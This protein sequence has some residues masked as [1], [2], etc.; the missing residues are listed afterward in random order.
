MTSNI[1]LLI[2]F[3]LRIRSNDGIIYMQIITVLHIYLSEYG[4]RLRVMNDADISEFKQ[5]IYL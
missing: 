4:K 3:R 1:L 5:N 2:V